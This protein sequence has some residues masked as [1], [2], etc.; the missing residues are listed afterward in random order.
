VLPDRHLDERDRGRTGVTIVRWASLAVLLGATSAGAQQQPY[1]ILTG[2]IVD[3]IHGGGLSGATVMVAGTDRQGTVDSTGRFRIDSIPPGQY[4]IGVFHPLLDSLN[5]SLSSNK[6]TLTPGGVTTIIMATPS[7]PSAIAMYCP[8]DE[9][10][11][12]SGVVIGRVLAMDTNDPITD[13]TVRYTSTWTPSANLVPR[14]FK[15]IR[16]TFVQDAKVK[17]DGSFTLCGLPVTGNGTVHATRGQV[18]TGE[19]LASVA[20]H[21][22]TMV[23]VLMDTLKHG[24]AVVIGR[25]ADDKGA[26]IP[27]VDVDLAGSRLKTQTSDSGTFALRDLPGGSQ[28][29]QVR[30]V[31]FAARDTSLLLSPKSPAQFAMTL[32]TAPV[33]LSTVNVEARRQ[34]L[35]RVGFNQRRKTGAGY[36]MTAD[37]IEHRGGSLFSD[38]ARTI[39]GL[40]VRIAQNGQPIIYQGRGSSVLN[41]SCVLY[42]VDGYPFQDFPRGSIDAYVL[43]QQM[44]G[45]EVYQPNESPPEVA[46]GPGATSCTIVAIW[47]RATSHEE[48]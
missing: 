22:L 41:Q 17:S 21:P 29:I 27:H 42:I 12:R 44:I 48:R 18:T 34:A 3:S 43:T 5:L 15:S 31:G 14:G 39:P 24:T 9:R 46:V 35:D 11:R 33:T 28:T 20:M 30:K 32:H 13:A 4:V 1:A 26:P 38:L 10:Q 40:T 23:T 16:T 6:V 47:T 45:I 19:V 25:I 37:D 36:Y 7:A 8:E 2:G